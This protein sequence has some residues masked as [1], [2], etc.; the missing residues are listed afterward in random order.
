MISACNKSGKVEWVG[1]VLCA[2]TAWGFC[3]FYRGK[4][5][6]TRPPRLSTSHLLVDELDAAEID[7]PPRPCPRGR[8]TNQDPGTVFGVHRA[9]PTNV[10]VVHGTWWIIHMNN[11]H[12][13]ANN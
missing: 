7:C 4:R 3:Y 2:S 11:N 5:C 6:P 12:V 9:F 8:E 1:G 10:V 13:V